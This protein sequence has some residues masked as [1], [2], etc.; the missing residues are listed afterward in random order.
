[1]S[2]YLALSGG[3]DAPLVRH[4][5]I[6]ERPVV[7]ILNL[8]RRVA[9]HLQET[10]RKAGQMFLHN[11]ETY[12]LELVCRCLGLVGFGLY[13]LSFLLLST[14]HISSVRVRYFA[15][16]LV[17]ALC[18]IASLAVDFNLSSALIQGFYVVISLTAMG[19]RMHRCH[20]EPAG[21]A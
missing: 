16:N 17:A 11:A 10:T 7:V 9:T 13:V 12:D 19:L 15:L 14:G 20:A 18:V 3:T 4:F 1:M 8:A 6:T 21:M 2:T 5:C